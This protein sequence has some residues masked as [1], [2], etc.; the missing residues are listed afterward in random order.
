MD[1]MLLFIDGSLG[2]RVLEEAWI[3]LSLWDI[4]VTKM[5]NFINSQK[6]SA[7]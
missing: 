3:F 7:F 2:V 5:Y 1:K 6:S 4:E